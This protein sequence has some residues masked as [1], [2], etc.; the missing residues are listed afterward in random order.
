MERLRRSPDRGSFGLT[1]YQETVVDPAASPAEKEEAQGML[2]LLNEW[3]AKELALEK[4]PNWAA[5]NLE[6]DL[7]ASDFI[8]DKARS[9]KYAQNL[10]AAL[11]NNDFLNKE[12][13]QWSCSW[14][15]AGG[16][17]ANIREEGDYI[18][19]YCSGIRNVH[20]SEEDNAPWD[21]Q[22]FV[23]EGVVTD[24]IRADLLALGWKVVKDNK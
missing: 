22:G 1:R 15:Y 12:N 7:R 17:V 9:E 20:Y 19:W 24:E 11:C 10:Y 8:A 6:Y 14:R 18:D 23:G 16:I 5:N 2:D 3:R 21:E 13:K 4:D